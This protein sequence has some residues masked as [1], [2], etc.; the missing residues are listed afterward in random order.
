MTSHF[1]L[2]CDPFRQS[3]QYLRLPL[4]QLKIDQSFVC[5]IVDEE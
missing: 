1:C 5:D 3:M 2:D 4:D